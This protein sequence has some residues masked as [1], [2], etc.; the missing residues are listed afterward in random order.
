[1]SAQIHAWHKAFTDP[2]GGFYERLDNNLKPID[3]PK[4]LVTQCRQL[5]VYA[6]A[7]IDVSKQYDFLQKNYRDPDTGGSRF[8]LGDD[9]YDLYGL[10]FVILACAALNKQDYALETIKFIDKNFRHTRS[11]LVN[12][13]DADLNPIAGPLTQNP[14]MH[15][16]ES[17]LAMAEVSGEQIYRVMADEMVE[18]FFDHFF[19]GVLHEIAGTDLIEAGHQSEWIWLLKRYRDVSG[20]DDPRIADA[21]ASLFDW[22]R[23]HASDIRHGGI[24][25]AQKRDGTIID[26][27]KRIWPLTETIRAARLMGDAKMDQDLSA[28]LKKSYLRPDG[29][30]TEIL[31]R[32]LTPF[33]DYLPGTTP[34]HLV[35]VLQ[36]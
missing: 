16:L 4:R 13:L 35:A 5:Y 21:M 22:V 3:Q 30:W 14:H 19:D 20:S 31:N 34:Y 9:T 6:S 2:A 15:L 23:L 12:A 29:F 8:S 24:F 28:V 26:D 11:G 32:D 1:M 33:T 36:K 7:G 18:L 10:T 27:K 17:C 25:N